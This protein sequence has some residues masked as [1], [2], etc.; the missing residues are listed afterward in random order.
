MLKEKDYKKGDW[1]MGE[2]ENAVA[3]PIVATSMQSVKIQ[4]TH[5]YPFPKTDYLPKLQQS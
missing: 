2:E 1:R 4:Y 5:K 3:L